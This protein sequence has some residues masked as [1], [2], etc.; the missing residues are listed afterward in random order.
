MTNDATQNPFVESDRD[1]RI[2]AKRDRLEDCADRAQGNAHTLH[3]QAKDMASVIPFGQPILIGHHSEQRDRNYRGRI[4]SKFGKA[5]AEQDKAEHLRS[6]AKTVGTG[7]VSSTAPDA[8]E[9]LQ[10][11]LEA[12]TTAQATMKL[13]NA[14]YR[15]GGIDGIK[16][17]SEK[18]LVDL[19][20]QMAASWHGSKPFASYSLSN[21]NANIRR[22]R[23]RIEEVTQLRES[24]ALELTH[25]DYRL[26][27]DNG[28][29]Q[30]EFKG[31]P[32]EQAR[33]VIK[34][35]T[36]KWSRYSGTWVRKATANAVRSAERA[37]AE[38]NELDSIY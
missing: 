37:A 16:C 23:Q 19:K 24:D 31:K 14:E 11:K 10:A 4:H 17:L 25:D 13:A 28:R 7:G 1:Q 21:N 29:L 6:K 2:E 38:L 32:N 12:L 5:F 18:Q 26:F 33:A 27:T 36:F 8:L 34:G 3:S 9:K 15:K 30:F 35:H 20:C 22:I